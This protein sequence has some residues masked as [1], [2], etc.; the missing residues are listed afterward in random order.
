MRGIRVTDE[1]AWAEAV[2]GCDPWTNGNC[3]RQFAKPWL[4]QLPGSDNSPSDPW[5]LVATNTHGYA[6]AHNPGIEADDM[7]E[8]RVVA[9]IG[10]LTTARTSL[11]L[12]SLYGIWPPKHA[13]INGAD[14][15]RLGWPRTGAKARFAPAAL[16]ELLQRQAVADIRCSQPGRM[17]PISTIELRTS[18][19]AVQA[20]FGRDRTG[21]QYERSEPVPVAGTAT[22]NDVGIVLQAQYLDNLLAIDGVKQIVVLIPAKSLPMLPALIDLQGS[23]S[24]LIV[25]IMPLRPARKIVPWQE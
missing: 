10:L 12:E 1:E 23:K 21:K 3:G 15:K 25:G 4:T 14:V 13:T 7:A 11:A 18:G 5:A 22:A 8:P 2:A 17:P 24:N 20:L 16:H 19:G 6:I 9:D